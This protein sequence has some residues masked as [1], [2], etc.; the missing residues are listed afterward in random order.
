[1]VCL[2]ACMRVKRH[3]CSYRIS[4]E[5]NMLNSVCVGGGGCVRACL[6]AC[7]RACV[8]ACVYGINKKQHCG[9]A[10]RDV[11]VK[12]EVLVPG[13]TGRHH[14][15]VKRKTHVLSLNQQFHFPAATF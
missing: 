6:L 11:P 12:S 3:L 14:G 4:L 2:A 15:S 13:R 8:R 1:M 5:L 7:V 9:Q 10:D